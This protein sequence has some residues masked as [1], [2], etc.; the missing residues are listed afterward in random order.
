MDELH[1]MFKKSIF[2]SSRLREKE[3]IHF[4][5]SEISRTYLVRSCANLTR[6]HVTEALNAARISIEATAYAY[7][8]ASGF[9]T[10]EEYFKNPN[11][12]NNL[13]KKI[14]TAERSGQFID[15]NM[16]SLMEF[17][18]FLSARGSHADPSILVDRFTSGDDGSIGI[19]FFQNP[20]DESLRYDFLG[21]IWSGCL[22]LKCYLIISRNIFGDIVDKELEEME[23]F[24]KKTEKYHRENISYP[25]PS[26]IPA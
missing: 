9:L 8:M 15:S 7:A 16:A 20:S 21:V 22:C 6:S 13:F 18:S 12:R 14:R 11:K 17:R 10:E 26:D 25:L 19:P 3:S 4:I 24:K 23:I 1:V 2:K 5:L